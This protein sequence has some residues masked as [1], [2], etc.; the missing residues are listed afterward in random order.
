MIGLTCALRL[1]EAG[2]G[3][4]VV[5]RETGELT[6]SSV[7][8]AV[9]YPYRAYPFERVLG[10][11]EASYDEFVA[12]ART[13]PA[14]GVRM[15]AGTE[16][17]PE[18]GPDPWWAAAVPDLAKVTGAPHVPAGF[19]IGWRFTAPV[20]DMSRYLPWLA[21]RLGARGVEIEQAEVAD[22]ADP[23]LGGPRGRRLRGPRRPDP[24]ARPHGQPR[25]RPGGRRRAGRPRRVGGRRA[26]TA[27]S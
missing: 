13:A 23:R 7:A 26:V 5:A 4:R 17:L 9:W 8:A 20:V 21:A 27:P 14:A 15:R 16:L 1:A 11:A 6:T 22:L 10:W 25:A 24:G 3:V 12:L 18:D 19:A 2:F